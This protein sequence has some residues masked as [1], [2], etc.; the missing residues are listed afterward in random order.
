MSH[1][2]KDCARRL[3]ATRSIDLVSSLNIAA[4]MSPELAGRLSLTGAIIMAIIPARRAAVFLKRGPDDGARVSPASPKLIRFLQTARLFGKPSPDLEIEL[5]TALCS[6]LGF[7]GR[8]A[9]ARLVV[10]MNS[11]RGRSAWK[12]PRRRPGLGVDP[13]ELLSSGSLHLLFKIQC[14]TGPGRPL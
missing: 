12:P 2:N 4:Q 11:Q 3:R 6:W 13:L 1:S 9:G 8:L 10:V 5:E 7:R 14:H